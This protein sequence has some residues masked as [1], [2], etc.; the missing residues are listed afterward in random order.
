MNPGFCEKM[1]VARVPPGRPSRTTIGTR[2]T[3]LEPLAYE[4][5]IISSY[6][7]R[8]CCRK[9]A[10]KLHAALRTVFENHRS[11][12]NTTPASYDVTAL[13]ILLN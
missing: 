7:N 3:G 10:W 5:G 2:T 12:S 8:I 13:A 4:V 11:T 1:E 6:S 9:I